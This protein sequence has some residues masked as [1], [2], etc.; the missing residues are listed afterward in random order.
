MPILEI[1]GLPG[2]PI[3]NHWQDRLRALADQPQSA[4]RIE[5]T[6]AVSLADQTPQ[7]VGVQL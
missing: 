1:L 5:P 7:T 6:E 3:E 2:K 4:R